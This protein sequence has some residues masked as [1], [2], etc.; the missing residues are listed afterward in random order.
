[1]GFL[2]VLDLRPQLNIQGSTDDSELAVYADAASDLV[3][4]WCGP[5]TPRV[6]LGELAY[7]T[8]SGFVLKLCP[9][10]SLQTVTFSGA[11]GQSVYPI[12]VVSDFTVDPESGV[13]ARGDGYRVDGPYRVDYT[14]GRVGTPGWALLAGKLIAQN[15]WETRRGP[16]RPGGGGPDAM[17]SGGF[18]I[19]N[20]AAA[21]MA[22]HRRVRVGI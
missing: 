1:M 4:E 3:E 6:V 13:V 14:A 17:T 18:A 7:G 21:V 10:L 20:Q 11:D 19:P 8:G 16:K 9:V 15:L 2:S 12:P 22:A 5:V